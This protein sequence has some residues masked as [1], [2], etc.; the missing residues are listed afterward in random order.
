MNARAPLLPKGPRRLAGG[1]KA[2]KL[3]A[4]LLAKLLART[5]HKDHRV[6]TGPG[7][8]RDAALISF[9]A[10]TLI[11]KTDPVT[12]VTDLIGWYAVQVNANDIA[13]SGGDPKWLLATVLLPVGS[14]PKL[15]ETIFE[16]VSKAAGN[17]DVE[18]VGGHTEVTIGVPRPIVVGMMLGE[19]HADATLTAGGARPGD[20]LILTKGIAIEGTAILAREA[21]QRLRAAGVAR[22]VINRAAKYLF[23]P[24]ISVVREAKAARS[25]GG[26]TA[27]HDPTEGGLATALA[28]LA[29]ASGYGV[30]VDVGAVLVLPETRAVCE[31]LRADPWGLIASGALLIAAGP[32]WAEAVVGAV[33]AIG[34]HAAVIGRVTPKNRG[35]V[36]R[37][38]GR[39]APLPRFER[40]E[41]ARLLEHG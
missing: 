26:V 30:E 37:R 39:R 10:T 31:A 22:T 28:E 9:G 20:V 34:V 5:E 6:L 24:G 17:L 15:A 19:A 1:L 38:G 21:A 14:T 7:V 11:A 23:D 16:Q 2:G 8:G 18:L 29:T 36:L 40:D 13:V 33:R 27:M 3:P 12:F 25:V 41:V 35:L 4:P 32:E